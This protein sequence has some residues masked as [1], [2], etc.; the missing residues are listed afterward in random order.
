MKTSLIILVISLLV[1]DEAFGFWKQCP[2]GT[3]PNAI[4]SPQ[5]DSGSCTVKRGDILN[6]EV[7]FIVNENH[8]SAKVKFYAVMLGLEIDIT[9]LGPNDDNVCHNLANG[10]TCPLIPGTEYI[11]N[12]NFL[13]P[14][15]IPLINNGLIRGMLEIESFIQFLNYS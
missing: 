5:C 9:T 11:W 1:V 6:G 3:P 14:L 10:L 13:V 15:K 2:K 8:A 7:T 12:I 4:V